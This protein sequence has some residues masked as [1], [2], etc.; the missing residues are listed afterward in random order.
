M[1]TGRRDVTNV[2]NQALTMLNDPFVAGQAE[3]WARQLIAKS[4][5]SPEQRLTVMFRHALGR[6]PE[7]GELTRWTQAVH[8]FNSLHQSRSDGSQSSEDLLQSVAVWKDT[9][10][11]LFNTTEFIYVR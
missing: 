2:P 11:A 6:E 4:H 5:D 8:D 9:A 7:A 3:F 1:P 10:H